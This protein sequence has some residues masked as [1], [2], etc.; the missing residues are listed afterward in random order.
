MNHPNKWRDYQ[1]KLKKK[2]ETRRLYRRLPAYAVLLCLLIL[3]GNG[4]FTLLDKTLEV[5]QKDISLIFN[6]DPIDH[7]DKH[8]RQRIVRQFHFQPVLKKIL[9]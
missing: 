4:L 6:D 2:A 9:N 5:Q 3:V 1:S 7:F 8:T